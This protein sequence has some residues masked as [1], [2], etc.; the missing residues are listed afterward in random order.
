MV[1]GG[2]NVNISA[3][4]IETIL[5]ERGITKATL[6]DKTGISRQNISTIIRRG[7]AEPKTVGKLAVGLGVNVSDIIEEAKP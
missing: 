7:T 2:E 3:T 5:A 6:A 4:K 1:I